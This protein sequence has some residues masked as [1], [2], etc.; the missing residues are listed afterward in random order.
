MNI[1]DIKVRSLF[2]ICDK[3]SIVP[4][5]EFNPLFNRNRHIT[6]P[7]T[8]RPFNAKYAN[9][10]LNARAGQKL[11]LIVKIIDYALNM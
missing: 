6:D 2:D 9:L 4:V 10:L 3:V 1:A 8:P 11:T 7:P 5:I